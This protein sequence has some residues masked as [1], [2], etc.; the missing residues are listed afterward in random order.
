M[1]K[2]II[3]LTG[4]LCMAVSSIA[5]D[6]YVSRCGNN[7]NEGT[8]TAPLSTLT[9]ARDLIRHYKTTRQFAQE[10]ITVWIDEGVYEQ[11]EPFV[12]NELDAGEVN[13]PIVWRA[14]EGKE[15]RISGGITLR[16]NSFSKVTCPAILNRLSPDARK[17]VMQVDLRPFGIRNYGSESQYGHALPVTESPIELFYNDSVMTVARYPNAGYMKIGEVIEMGSQPRIGDYTEKGGSFKYIDPRHAKWVGQSDIWFQGTFRYGF[18]DDNLPV[19][20]IDAKKGVVKMASPHLYGLAGGAPYQQYFAKNILDELDMPGEWYLDKTS[21]MLYFW[22][23]TPMNTNSSINLS[24]L[25]DPIIC[26]EGV[27]HVALRDLTVEVGRGIGIYLER[28]NNNLIAGCTVRNVGTSG[29]FMGLGAKQKM[30]YITH[31]HYDG[32]PISRRIGSQQGHLY[33]YTAWD[34]MAGSN[35]GILSC[36]IYN[37]GTGGIYLS[38]GNK[39]KLI[40][41]NSY[42]ENCR[43]SNYNRRNKFCWA[44]INVD[45]CGNRIS[46]CEIFNSEWQGIYVHG[47][48]HLFE[49]NEIH[50]VTLDSNDT[51]PWYIGRD[52]SDRGNVIRYNYLH[53]CG[54]K[55][56]MNMGIYCDDSS[57]DVLVYGNVFYKM[58]TTHGVLFSNSGWDLTFKNNIVIEPIAQTTYVS[59][60]YYLWAQAEIVPA[61]GSDGLLRKRLTQQVDIYNPPYSERYPALVD[62]LNP[63]VDGK[64]WEGVRSRRNIACKNLIVGG[65]EN[66]F[67]LDGAHAQCQLSENWQVAQDPGFVDYSKGNFNLKP[68]SEVFQKIAGFESLPF[69]RMGLYTDEYR[70]KIINTSKN[71]EYD[72]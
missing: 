59:S 67:K 55:D 70:T 16:P 72:N 27:H 49:Y 46:H 33:K 20:H 34:R 65:P 51:S 29:I 19:A 3:L 57:T 9:A 39:A 26:M 18:A 32:F 42:V 44:G 8:M 37:T 25:E 15:V 45:G 43:I 71:K 7:E 41:G 53:H 28:A 38:G 4:L 60:H 54:N 61:F 56:R 22:P 50:H 1:N 66:P 36:D 11:S 10:G 12:L 2:K 68:T 6:I 24:I 47:N 48:D 21:S 63:I 13:Q 40:P 52:P 17:K 58:N 62:Y 31:E 23:V 30:S 35:N 64:E 69:D 14:I 5:K